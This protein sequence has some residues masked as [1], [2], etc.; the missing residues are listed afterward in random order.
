MVT[1]GKKV[2]LQVPHQD[3]DFNVLGGVIEEYVKYG[4]EATVVFSTNGDYN[5]LAETRFREAQNAL[6]HIG[7]PKDHPVVSSSEEAKAAF[8]ETSIVVAGFVENNRKLS[9]PQDFDPVLCKQAADLILIEADGA[10]NLPCKVPAAHEPVIPEAAD[11]VIGV[12]GMDTPGKRLGEIC[13]R[14]AE[15]MTFLGTDENHIM[16]ID[17][18]AAILTSPL[19]TMKGVGEK[20][21]IIVLNKCDDIHRKTLA[22]DLRKV[23]VQKGFADVFCMSVKQTSAVW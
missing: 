18:M 3:D 4:S 14:K 7:I 21:Y 20:K 10:K 19:G 16:T 22:A 5:G 2:M 12:I 1:S 8:L 17:D 13:F 11:I 9:Q 15:T 6:G 23:L